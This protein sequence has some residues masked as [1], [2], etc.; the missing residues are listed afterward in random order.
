MQL[1]VLEPLLS[2]CRLPA[3]NAIP[4][5]ALPSAFLSI[6]RTAE[7]LSIVLESARCP[8]EVN[9][10]TSWK[11]L[12][13]EGPLDFSL[14]GIIQSLSAVLANAGIS[15]FIISTFDTDYILVKEAVVP[16][17]I[18]ALEDAGHTISIHER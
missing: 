14:V 18:H 9:Q 16:Q 17:A 13:V 5:W 12:K 4:S 8:E 6:T 11:A 3:E 2:I 1:T 15:V 7:E 10:N